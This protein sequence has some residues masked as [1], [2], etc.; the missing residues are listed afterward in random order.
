M[1]RGD[2]GV[3]FEG[4]G[5]GRITTEAQRHRERKTLRGLSPEDRSYYPGQ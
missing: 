3:G 4:G 2:A 1:S 5:E